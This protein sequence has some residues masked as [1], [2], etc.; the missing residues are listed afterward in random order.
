MGFSRPAFVG[1]S[2]L[3]NQMFDDRYETTLV[4]LSSNST[5]QIAIFDLNANTLEAL[6]RTEIRVAE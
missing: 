3:A 4:D 2:V 1:D 5:R 6:E